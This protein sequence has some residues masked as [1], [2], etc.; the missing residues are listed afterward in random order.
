MSREKLEKKARMVAAFV[1]AAWP[2]R[3]L[4]LQLHYILLPAMIRGLQI[5]LYIRHRLL[6][7]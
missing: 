1:W 2:A 5:F 7:R 3:G 6:D 4:F